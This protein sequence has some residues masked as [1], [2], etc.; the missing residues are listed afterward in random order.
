MT[1][2]IFFTGCVKLRLEYEHNYFLIFH[3]SSKNGAQM[4]L[5]KCITY[6]GFNN[7]K[8]LYYNYD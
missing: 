5:L 3:L 1:D 4:N 7:E 8:Q 2:R 6:S